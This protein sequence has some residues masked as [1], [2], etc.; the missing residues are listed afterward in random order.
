MA[1]GSAGSN[2]VGIPASVPSHRP[3]NRG[4]RPYRVSANGHGDVFGTGDRYGLDADQDVVGADLR[5]RSTFAQLHD[6]RRPEGSITQAFTV[7]RT[8]VPVLARIE[9]SGF[10]TTFLNSQLMFASV[11]RTRDTRHFQP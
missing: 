8:V 11:A 6:V 2:P 4:A 1:Y 5:H 3:R 10:S 7:G 9:C